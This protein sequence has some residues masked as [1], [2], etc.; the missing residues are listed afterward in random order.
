MTNPDP[1]RFAPEA[2][3]APARVSADARHGARLGLTRGQRL[4]AT[5]TAAAILVS[6]LNGLVQVV[7]VLV[8]CWLTRR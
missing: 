3:T 5:A 7:R 4:L 2:C 6:G 1:A 8:E